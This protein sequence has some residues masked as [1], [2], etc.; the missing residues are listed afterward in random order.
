MKRKKRKKWL[1]IGSIIFSLL[2][3]LNIIASFFF[4]N[5]AIERNVKDFLQGNDDLVVSEEAMDE[6]LKGDWRDWTKDQ[7][8]A[9]MEI[10]SFDELKLQGY[11]LEAKEPTN[12]VVITAHGYL[13]G[14]FDMGLY[15]KHYYEDLGYHFFTADARGHGE[16]EGDYIGFGWHD[17]LD[18]IQWIDEIINRL[19]PDVEIV[20]HGLSMGAATVLMA[21][22]EELPP[23]V[24]AIVA[25]SPYTSV[26]DL[27]SYQLNRMFYLPS[28]PVIPT[29]SVVTQAKAGYS[30]TEASALNQVKKTD[31]PILYMH[32]EE[33]TF[34]PT[35]LAKDLYEETNSEA[36][37]MFFPNANHGE[38]YVIEKELYLEKLHAFLDLYIHK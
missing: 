19:G 3:I 7:K 21:S 15:G 4:Y 32:G 24:K 16:S 36:D 28:F 17:R 31:I 34:V 11:L 5:L 1:I 29:L 37:I 22:G 2:L 30:L 38:G 9:G 13:G 18:Y 10:T 12:K 33:D 14:A 23:Q 25:D 8:F 27:F 6:F 26:K 20:L 35:T